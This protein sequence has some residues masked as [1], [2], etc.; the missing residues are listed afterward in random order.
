MSKIPEARR[1]G[2]RRIKEDSN[3][4]GNPEV[5]NAAGKIE[6]PT[7]S[8]ILG[9]VNFDNEKSDLQSKSIE[10]VDPVLDKYKKFIKN[11]VSS[12]NPILLAAIEDIR[13]NL[14]VAQ[15]QGLRGQLLPINRTLSNLKVIAVRSLKYC[16]YKGKL[17]ESNYIRRY[18][19]SIISSKLVD[20][21]IAWNSDKVLDF[22][23]DNY[24]IVEDKDNSEMLL[25]GLI[26]AGGGGNPCI[27]N[28]NNSDSDEDEISLDNANAFII[29]REEIKSDE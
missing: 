1:T 18:S 20:I 27:D 8:R 14:D 21:Y 11:V 12:I 10:K 6:S 2:A 7:A 17:F 23:D 26:S 4:V 29:G 25:I 9:A 22:F 19:G 15:K 28:S 5:F 13:G 24:Y 3:S 16:D